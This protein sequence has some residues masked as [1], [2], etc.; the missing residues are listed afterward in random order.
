[1]LLRDRAGIVFSWIKKLKKMYGYCCVWLLLWWFCLWF[2]L[3]RV[4]VLLEGRIFHSI[5]I[6]RGS[7]PT[8]GNEEDISLG[9][10]WD[11][12]VEGDRFD[13]LLR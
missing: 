3:A 11:D 1:M 4:G 8:V 10:K 5:G 6:G 2:L 9:D 12:M 7:D 13:V